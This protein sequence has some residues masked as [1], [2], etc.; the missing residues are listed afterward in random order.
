MSSPAAEPH[1]AARRPG[2]QIASL[3]S[4]VGAHP[5]AL[6]DLFGAGLPTD[7]SDPAGLDGGSGPRTPGLGDAP[8]GR[9]LAFA[10]GADVFL[11]FRP[12]L[13]AL[14]GDLMP[15]RGK[16]FD[17]GGNSGQDLLLDRRVFRFQAEVGPS[18]IDGRPALVL[19]YDSAAHGNPWPIRAIRDELRTVGP[20][21]AIGPALF[22]PPGSGAPVSLFWFGLQ[23]G[24]RRG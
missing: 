19:T 9:L 22:Q 10:L 4:L 24:P 1:A 21:V 5:D 20:G 23:G 12:L 16:S 18:K 17:H 14:A 8:R 2:T 6:L 7:P 3:D 11:A 15:W 13:R